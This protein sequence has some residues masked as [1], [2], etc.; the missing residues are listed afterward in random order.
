VKEEKLGRLACVGAWEE[1]VDVFRARLAAEEGIGVNIVPL[2]G[3]A[4]GRDPD[5]ECP[6]N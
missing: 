1:D 5:D 2:E 4:R 3:G 6:E